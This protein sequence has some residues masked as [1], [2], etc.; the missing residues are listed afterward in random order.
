MSEEI[1]TEVAQS[2]PTEAQQLNISAAD[3]VSRRL[4][5]NTPPVE[6]KEEEVKEAT[7]ESPVVENTESEVAEQTEEPQGSDDV[8]SQLDLDDMSEDDLKELS[9]KLGS[10]A[11]A[12]YG[13]LTAKRKAAEAKLSELQSKLNEQSPLNPAEDIDNNPYSNLESLE[14]LQ[15]KA[16]EVNQVIEWAEDT[17]FSADGSGPD[18]EIA[19]VEG[20]ALTKAE[21]RASL[22]NARKARDKFLPAQLRSLQA[23]EQSTQ[24]ESAFTQK[25]QEELSWLKGEDNDLRKQYE[26]II[27]DERFQK[28]RESAGPDVRPQLNYL[29]AHAANSIY[30]RQLVKGGVASPTLN[31]T[32]TG[33]TGA[34]TSEK[35]VNKSTK[36]LKDL[37]QRFKSSGKKGDFI[38]LRTLQLKNR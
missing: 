6:A 22:L 13:E 11:V 4:G 5:Q 9:E 27:G 1:T 2:V 28:L 14:D 3:F 30:G 20:K 18:D 17:L 8:L 32:R 15:S 16:K 25:A 33:A 31:P 7:D 34:S 21:V 38:S 10:R 24:L 37:S 26:A 12:R 23:E 19:E 29:M 35:T 36:A